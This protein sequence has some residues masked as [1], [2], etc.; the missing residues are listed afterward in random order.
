MSKKLMKTSE[1]RIKYFTEGSR[2]CQATINRWIERGDL[3]GTK[4]GSS[5]YVDVGKTDLTGNPLVD[6]VLMAS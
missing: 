2:P 4:I 5:Y 6:A 3:P 1:Y